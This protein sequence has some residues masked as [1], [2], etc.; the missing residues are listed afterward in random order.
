MRRTPRDGKP[1]YCAICGMG[2]GEYIACES[3]DCELE[4]EAV[5]VARWNDGDEKARASND[6][7]RQRQT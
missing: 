4:L 5:A 6:R 1:Y 7:S 3:V 2:W